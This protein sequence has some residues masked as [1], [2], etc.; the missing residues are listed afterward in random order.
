MKVNNF[1]QTLRNWDHPESSW[2]SVPA[3]HPCY[4]I[5]RDGLSYEETKTF[6]GKQFSKAD[7]CTIYINSLSLKIFQMLGDK[8]ICFK[9]PPLPIC[10]C[11]PSKA[12]GLDNHFFDCVPYAI[13]PVEKLKYFIG[14]RQYMKVIE[15]NKC[16][17]WVFLVVNMKTCKVPYKNR[18]NIRVHPYTDGFSLKK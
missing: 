5:V 16:V 8:K 6:Q 9:I 14:K 10:S 15:Y 11:K 18:E 7:Y 4:C 12:C 1:T 17:K 2:Y 3:P 13:S